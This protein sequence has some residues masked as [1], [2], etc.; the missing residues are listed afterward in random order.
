M[1]I[2]SR[3]ITAEV[4]EGPDKDGWV[5]L[6]VRQCQVLSEVAVGH[7]VEI[8]MNGKQVRRS[9]STILRGQPERLLW[10]DEAA[11]SV[12]LAE[13]AAQSPKPPDPKN[14]SGSGKSKRSRTRRGTRR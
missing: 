9:I 2:G 12:V 8:F 6:L 4:T 13:V 11:R 14:R 7:D 10:S 1:R 5:A 3:R